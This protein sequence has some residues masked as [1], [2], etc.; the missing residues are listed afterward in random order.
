MAHPWYHAVLAARRYGGVP[1]DYLPLESWMDATKSHMPDCRHRLFLH[2]S[3]GIYLAERIH[4]VTLTRASDGKIVPIRPLLEDHIVQDFGKIPTLAACLSQ[5]APEPVV[6]EMTIYDQ[7]LASVVRWGGVWTDY[8]A[9][10]QF[11]DWPREH[12]ADGRSRRVLHNSWGIALA[13]QA[14]GLALTRP[15]DQ[16]ALDVQ[17][18]VEQHILCEM[19]SIPTLE[20]SLEG[21]TLQRWMCAR[22][23]PLSTMTEKGA[24]A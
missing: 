7:C 1:Q 11:M 14:F 13:V 10:H 19:P 22:A 8:Q 15:S 12:L 5:L 9:V 17:L 21:I 18:L 23:R 16:V 4:G 6:G 24:S 3:W 20:A 2:N